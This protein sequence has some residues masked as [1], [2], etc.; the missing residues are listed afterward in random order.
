MILDGVERLRGALEPGLDET[1]HR[2]CR[3]EHGDG[4]R[5][6]TEIEQHSAAPLGAR[7]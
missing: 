4:E 1:R 7:R 3:G 5:L 6:H 2:R